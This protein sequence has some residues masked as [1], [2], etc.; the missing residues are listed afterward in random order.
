MT[1]EQIAFSI[2]TMKEH[3][4]VDSG[5]SETLGIGCMN[6]ARQKS[7]Y[8]KMVAAGVIKAGIDY[9]KTYT[10]EFVCKGLG[11]ELKK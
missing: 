7:F 4:I 9:T 10:T 5:D 3:G 8:D 2:A 11:L 1:D 6:D